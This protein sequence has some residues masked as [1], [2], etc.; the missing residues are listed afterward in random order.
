MF[1]LQHPQVMPVLEVLICHSLGAGHAVHTLIVI[2][3]GSLVCGQTPA[4]SSLNNL[5][6]A[7][8]ATSNMDTFHTGGGRYWEDI[9]C[10]LSSLETPVVQHWMSLYSPYAS[11]SKVPQK[12]TILLSAW[13]RNMHKE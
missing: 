9:N 11:Q 6:S 7:S 13:H 10:T 4:Y 2:A 8:T 12:S 3:L 5:P 1:T